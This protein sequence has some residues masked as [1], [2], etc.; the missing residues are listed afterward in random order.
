MLCPG[1]FLMVIKFQ[2]IELSIK[3]NR[4]GELCSPVN[5]T[6]KIHCRG[7]ESPPA[8][9]QRSPLQRCLQQLDK[10]GFD[11]INIAQAQEMEKTERLRMGQ[12]FMDC[13]GK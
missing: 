13:M 4:R 8:G 5:C 3:R 1:T 2:F 12:D 10:P 6:F 7:G 11:S 9:D